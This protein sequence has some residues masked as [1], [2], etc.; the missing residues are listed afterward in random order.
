MMNTELMPVEAPMAGVAERTPLST[1]RVAVTHLS[2][3]DTPPI[4][5]P[6]TVSAAPQTRQVGG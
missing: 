5:I 6:G 3:N 4:G 2:G 1:T